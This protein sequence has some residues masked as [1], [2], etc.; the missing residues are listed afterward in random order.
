[1][2]AIRALC[3]IL[4]AAFRDDVRRGFRA[5]REHGTVANPFPVFVDDDAEEVVVE[6][7]GALAVWSAAA[8]RACGAAV[9]AA[10]AA[11]AAVAVVEGRREAATI[12]GL[13][14]GELPEKPAVLMQLLYSTSDE[15]QGS[16]PSYEHADDVTP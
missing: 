4:K 7:A 14:A 12:S 10:A 1:M 11:A 3:I 16:R 15:R 6:L 5:F 9:G 8:R 2:G 13:A